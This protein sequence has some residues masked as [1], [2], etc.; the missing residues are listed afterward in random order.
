MIFLRNLYVKLN[1]L[2]QRLSY[3]VALSVIAIVACAIVFGTLL[4]SSYA[5]SHHRNILE[6]A[7]TSQNINRGDEHAVRL[8]ND[9][10]MNVEGYTYSS[11]L[12]KDR[13][14]HIF[15]PEGDIG[16]PGYVTRLLLLDLRPTWAPEWLLEQPD[17]TWMLTIVTSTWLLMVIW[18]NASVP[19][20]MT[21]VLMGIPLGIGWFYKSFQATLGD[22]PIVNWP[23]FLANEHVMLY[24]GG[25]GLFT[26]TFI[27]LTNLVMILYSRPNQVLAVAHTLMKEAS[28]TKLSLVFIILLLVILPLLPL[29][30]DPDS[31]LRFQVQ[32]FISRSFM[33]T[34]AITALLTIF[35]SCASI[36]FEIRDRQIWQLMTKPMNRLSYLVGK[37]LGVMTLNLIILI[38][39]GLST[40]TFIQ[41]LRIQPVAPGIEGQLDALAVRD[42]V[43]T[44]RVAM[45]PDYVTL[46]PEQLIIREEAIIAQ[47][48]ELSIMEDIPMS[49][50]RA[51]R[52]ELQTNNRTGQRTVPALMSKSYIFSGL[53]KAKQLQSSLTLRYR[54]FIM[55]NS[56]HDVFTAVFQFN[57]D[58]ASARIRNYVP[59]QT[60][61]F[62]IGTDL[63]RE[64][65]TL[66]LDIYNAYSTTRDVPSAGAL[67]F[68][69]D[70]LDIL[71]KV[72]NF[73]GNFFRAILVMW[74]KLSFLSAL[75]IC[76]ATFLSFPVAC[77]SS[78]TIFLAGLLAPFVS[79]SL[80]TF[81]ID[82]WGQIPA[83][84]IGAKIRWIFT[85]SVH[86]LA[87][88][89][90]YL[91]RG[92]G[93]YKPTRS[94]VA[95]EL[96]SWWSVFTGF[97]RLGVAWS[98]IS[99]VIGYLVIRN[100]Q[101][102]IYSG[103]G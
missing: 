37:W 90:V 93:E 89:I 69:D 60:H 42:Q 57:D 3:R 75:G 58:P 26:F 72:A 14:E 96:I 100:R 44:A 33:L 43:L 101:L 13:P 15:T 9:G 87:Y 7:L 56:E 62:P 6:P 99:M 98:C 55:E 68:E 2:Q 103:N 71:Y 12:I 97:L 50:R 77:L 61:V 88:G 38:V 25:L 32:T 10:E 67:N 79:D 11:A 5:L 1:L 64:D 51:I 102:A 47:D 86:S 73:E 46:T 74:F 92:F 66:K 76:C 82:S 49:V 80:A 8:F 83:G 31:P 48:S 78:F 29:H 20:F 94:L 84:E 35:L 59:T 28:R 21:L 40:F 18:L 45:K 91:V 39:A 85:W 81:T 53:S 41:Y 63:I 95:G 36:A 4:R 34:F 65:G 19:L 22:I 70:G 52:S 27:L 30:L 24:I 23:M 17:T 16:S 54:F